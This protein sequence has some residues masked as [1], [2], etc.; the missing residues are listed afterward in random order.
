M[1]LKDAMAL[2]GMGT[3]IGLPLAFAAG[4][5][6]QSLLYGLNGFDIVTSLA[7]VMALAVVAAFSGYIP[8]R[9]AANLDPMVA[10]R[11]E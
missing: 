9:R 4:R 6:L 5:A 8:A 7:A 1:V 11:N 3:I 2:V 10:L